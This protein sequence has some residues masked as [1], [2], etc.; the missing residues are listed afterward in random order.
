MI[1]KKIFFSFFLILFLNNCAQNSISLLGP[2]Y[3]LGT[4][5]NAYQAGLSYTT[6]KAIN[7]IT[8]KTTQENIKEI[9]EPNIN[10]DELQKFLKA[11]IAKTRKL[12]DL[13]K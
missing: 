3:T 12:L 9:L 11:R 6:N 10:D 8:G 4:T 5:G 7:E 13:K 2:A 1:N